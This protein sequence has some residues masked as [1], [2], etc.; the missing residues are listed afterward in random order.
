ME[1]RISKNTKK[2]IN[3]AR[4]L[5]DAFC[6]ETGHYYDGMNKRELDILLQQFYAGM[7]SEKGEEYCKK[8]MISMIYGI[9]KYFIKKCEIYVIN[10]NEIKKRLVRFSAQCVQS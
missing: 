3:V 4:R 1:D 6:S 7:R 8:S 2:V 9:Q 5:L 10:E